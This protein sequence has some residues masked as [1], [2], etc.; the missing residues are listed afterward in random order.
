M[1]SLPWGIRAGPAWPREY[2]EATAVGLSGP[3]RE[4]HF[5]FHLH[6]RFLSSGPVTILDQPTLRSGGCSVHRKVFSSIPGLYPLDSSGSS[7]LVIKIRSVSRHSWTGPSWRPLT[8]TLNLLALGTAGHR[9]LRERCGQEHVGRSWDP[10]LTADCILP[11]PGGSHLE[12]DQAQK[13][14]GA[15][16]KMMANSTGARSVQVDHSQ[17]SD[18]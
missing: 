11:S 7:R 13:A 16:Q 9:V 4:R 8:W 6:P 14:G 12:R 17:I 18:T 2:T 1:K 15:G 3:G 5:T 10:Q